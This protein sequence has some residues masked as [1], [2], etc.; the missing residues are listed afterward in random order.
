MAFDEVVRTRRT[1]RTFDERLMTFSEL[2]ALLDL[3]NGITG[4]ELVPGGGEIALRAAPSAGALYPIELYLAVRR[5]DGLAAGLY[6]YEPHSLSLALLRSGD[7]TESVAKVC[8]GSPL[9]E[10]A[11][12]TVFF[13]GVFDRTLRKYG[14]RGYRY[15]LLDAGHVAQNLCLAATSKALAVTTTCGFF[16]D[17]ANELLGLGGLDESVL[18]V[19]FVGPQPV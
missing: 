5:V 18:Y 19:A 9:A 14:D 3:T 16:D 1:I 6:H 15:V 8:C 17:Q 2:G 7:P 12:V 11:S 13:S 10:A 4:V